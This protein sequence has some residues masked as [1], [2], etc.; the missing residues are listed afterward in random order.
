MKKCGRRDMVPAVRFSPH[1]E[2]CMIFIFCIDLPMNTEEC[3]SEQ[4]FCL[5]G[6]CGLAALC[7]RTK[8]FLH[9]REK[10]SFL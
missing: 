2:L 3:I 7:G 4:H 9:A 5:A 10:Q 8:D 1:S 6:L